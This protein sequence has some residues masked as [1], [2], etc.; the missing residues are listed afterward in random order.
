MSIYLSEMFRSVLSF[1][2]MGK[3]SRYLPSEFNEN[4][5]DRVM[6]Y[7]G[8]DASRTLKPAEEVYPQ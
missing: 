5:V 2:N 8:I 1:M 7:Q 6:N 4:K 3:D